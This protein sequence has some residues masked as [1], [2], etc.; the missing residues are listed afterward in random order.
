[1]QDKVT[2][3][4]SRSL[5]AHPRRADHP[6]SCPAL[7]ADRPFH[8]AQR[9]FQATPSLYGLRAV[10]EPAV[11]TPIPLKFQRHG[12][13]IVEAFPQDLLVFSVS[14][15]EAFNQ[16]V[17]LVMLHPRVRVLPA[18][19]ARGTSVDSCVGAGPC[20]FVVRND[21]LQTGTASYAA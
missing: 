15:H 4:Q 2:H 19:P 3:S 10:V 11:S 12:L 5:R 17:G 18:L 8:G 20:V 1:M 21:L 14:Q 13:S 6:A 7:K 16:A 9:I